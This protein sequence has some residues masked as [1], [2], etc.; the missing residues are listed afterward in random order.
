M[1]KSPLRG[2]EKNETTKT[3][4]GRARV[5]SSRAGFKRNLNF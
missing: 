3:G 2:E 1:E 4:N 5:G